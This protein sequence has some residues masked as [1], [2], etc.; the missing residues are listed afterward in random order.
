MRAEVAEHADVA[1][2]VRGEE[3]AE[4]NPGRRRLPTGMPAAAAVL[5]RRP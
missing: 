2:D 5:L 1:H 3:P 4:R